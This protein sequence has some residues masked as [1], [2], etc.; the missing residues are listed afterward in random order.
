MFA[1]LLLLV[2]FAAFLY[3]LWAVGIWIDYSFRYAYTL[4]HRSAHDPDL[5]CEAGLYASWEEVGGL[6]CAL[7][8]F[9]IVHNLVNCVRA[10]LARSK[11]EKAKVAPSAAAV[12]EMQ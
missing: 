10:Q 12:P 4:H 6:A 2:M 9:G 7:L 8:V 11:S 5:P 1:F 3:L